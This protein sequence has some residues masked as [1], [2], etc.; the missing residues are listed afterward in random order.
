MRKEDLSENTEIARYQNETQQISFMRWV[1]VCTI[2]AGTVLMIM[3]IVS[4][5]ILLPLLSPSSQQLSPQSLTVAQQLA[6]APKDVL[7]FATALVGFAGGIVTAMFRTST[8]TLGPS[9]RSSRTSD[10]SGISSEKEA[11]DGSPM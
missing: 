3:S 7:P 9:G 10:S 2:V 6:M 11:K 8:G 1:L 4:P 5:L